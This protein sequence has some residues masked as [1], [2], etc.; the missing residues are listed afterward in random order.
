[1]LLVVK[2]VLIDMVFSIGYLPAVVS[3]RLSQH[4]SSISLM[5]IAPFTLDISNSDPDITYCVEVFNFT[6]SLNLQC[7]ITV[8]EFTYPLHHIGCDEFYSFTVT[9]VNAAGRGTSTSMNYTRLRSEFTDCLELNLNPFYFIY[10]TL[11]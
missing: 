10:S 3:L 9:P 11:C 1:M 2:K 7:E 8:T 5:W 4:G 6:A